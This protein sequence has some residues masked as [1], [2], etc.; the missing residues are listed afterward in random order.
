MGVFDAF[1]LLSFFTEISAKLNQFNDGFDNMNLR[2]IFLF[3]RCHH[4]HE[5]HFFLNCFSFFSWCLIHFIH[6]IVYPLRSFITLYYIINMLAF[7]C[8]LSSSAFDAHKV[9]SAECMENAIWGHE[10]WT[11][12]SVCGLAGRNT[13][14]I[15]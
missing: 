11:M 9:C 6:V 3:A 5:S 15:N 14:E 4:L 8:K 13:W 12:V 10:I 1:D 2:A 7:E